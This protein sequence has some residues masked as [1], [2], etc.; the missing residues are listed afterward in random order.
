MEQNNIIAVPTGTI[1]HTRTDPKTGRRRAA[2]SAKH[3]AVAAGLGRIGKNTLLTTPEYGNMVWLNVILTDAELEPDEILT[4][5]PCGDNCSLCID[6][7]PA[8]ALG[9]PE[10]NQQACGTYAF[11]SVEGEE[12]SF[13]CYL[14]RTICPNCFG[15]KNMQVKNK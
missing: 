5:D 10:M 15:S 14:C 4:G 1:S 9:S 3:C 11:R 12:F 2:V 6:N 7:C 13:K 8:N